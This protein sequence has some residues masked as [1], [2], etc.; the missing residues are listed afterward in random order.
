MSDKIVKVC[1]MCGR[2]IKL[3]PHIQG[4][5]IH[6]TL[7]YKNHNGI[8]LHESCYDSV[9]VLLNKLDI[10]EFKNIADDVFVNGVNTL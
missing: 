2:E 3:V 9:R 1:D 7:F 8:D 4:G 10:P 5:V 6:S